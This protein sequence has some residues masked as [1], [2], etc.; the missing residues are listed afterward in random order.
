MLGIP[1][2]SPNLFPFKCIGTL[3][4]EITIMKTFLVLLTF[5]FS[6]SKVEAI[7]ALYYTP[8]GS[9]W[10]Y[11][12]IGETRLID[13]SGQNVSSYVEPLY[14][15]VQNSGAIFIFLTSVAD[16]VSSFT[17]SIDPTDKNPLE[18]GTYIGNRFPIEGHNDLGFA[19]G[20]DG[21][22]TGSSTSWVTILEVEYGPD[23]VVPTK[24]AMDFIHFED[25]GNR[26]DVNFED[27]R[28]SFGSF[29]FNSS[30]PLTAPV[31]EPAS[32]MFMGVAIP[33]FLRRRR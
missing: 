9:Q 31:P 23:G 27:Y 22:T 20:Q 30:V 14:Q 6:F 11:M 4:F 32:V 2:H 21:R 28:Y 7:T 12:T 25:T 8:G 17:L 1:S 18:P 15:S 3:V 29:R 13:L 24:L 16:R 5:L 26:L 33:F 10:T 19:W